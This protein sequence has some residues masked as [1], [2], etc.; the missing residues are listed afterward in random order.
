M[1]KTNS[2]IGTVRGHVNWFPVTATG[3]LHGVDYSRGAGQ[4][5]DV[6]IDLVVEEPAALTTGN[7]RRRHSGHRGYHI[8]FYARESVARLPAGSSWWHALRASLF[9]ADLRESVGDRRLAIVTGLFGLDGV[10]E[11]QS[12]LHPVFGMSVLVDTLR[13]PEGRLQERWAVMV[14]NLANEG[15]CATG[16]FPLYTGSERD[17]DQHFVI[18]FGW[19]A[20][21]G[22]ARVS[23]GPS[24]SSHATRLPRARTDPGRHLYVDFQH[25]RPRPTDEDFLFLGTVL[26]EWTNDGRGPWEERFDGWYPDDLSFEVKAAPDRDVEAKALEELRGKLLGDLPGRE[27]I[28]ARPQPDQLQPVAAGPLR[29]IQPRWNPADTA[30][31]EATIPWSYRPVLASCGPGQSTLDPL[32]KGGLRW[33]LAPSYTVDPK[34]AFTPFV[35]LFM[36]SHGWRGLGRLGEALQAFAWRLDVRWDQLRLR[37]PDPDQDADPRGLGLRFG[38]SFQA[39]NFRFTDN[40]VLSPYISPR[41]TTFFGGDRVRFGWGAASGLHL[42]IGHREFFAEYQGAR[43]KGARFQHSVALGVILAQPFR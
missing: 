43:H 18:D 4:D 23:L 27:A 12:E 11:F 17:V 1:C 29:P 37:S 21:A 40:G 33:A 35:Y 22:D 3:L 9:D 13:T 19:W 38:P 20:G 16:R 24:W 39:D 42:Q 41:I 2:Q 31:A 14:Q 28:M 25:P 34:D 5:N 8:E 10:H 7:D 6:T 26:V 36:A 30:R 32:C 15:D